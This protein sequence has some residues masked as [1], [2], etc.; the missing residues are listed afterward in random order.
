MSLADTAVDLAQKLAGL[1][2]AAIF[3]L[4]AAERSWELYQIRKFAEDSN[5]K[6]RGTREKQIAS[7]VMHTEALKQL[8]EKIGSLEM[9]L[10]KYV[11]KGQA[12][13]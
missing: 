2:P 13:V 10:L 12:N 7:D 5:E 3:A 8:T 1:T 4:V 11:L 9:V 6:W